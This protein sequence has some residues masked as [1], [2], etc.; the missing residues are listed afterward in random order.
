MVLSFKQG[1]KG[2]SPVALW[3]TPKNTTLFLTPTC[4]EFRTHLLTL[5]MFIKAAETF[6]L[7][8]SKWK[9]WKP[10]RVCSLPLVMNIDIMLLLFQWHCFTWHDVNVLNHSFGYFPPF[11]RCD[12]F[13]DNPISRTDHLQCT[14]W[15][16]YN[17]SSTPPLKWMLFFLLGAVW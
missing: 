2:F 8:M 4:A 15:E 6:N 5:W 11:F 13:S 9:C 17:I 16:K 3:Q 1:G 14:T 10:D 12:V 7:D